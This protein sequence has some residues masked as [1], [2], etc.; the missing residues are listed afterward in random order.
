MREGLGECCH[1]LVP[2]PVCKLLSLS[3]RYLHILNKAI[4]TQLFALL[5]LKAEGTTEHSPL[6]SP[7]L[8]ELYDQR[9]NKLFCKC[10]L[11]CHPQKYHWQT[12]VPF[13]FLNTKDLCQ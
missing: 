10:L 11:P 1:L 5:F 9:M 6:R 13:C 4:F 7:P 12:V 8:Q 3:K 2:P